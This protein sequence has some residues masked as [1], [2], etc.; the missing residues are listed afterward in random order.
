MR[1][2]CLSAD[3]SPFKPIQNGNPATRPARKSSVPRSPPRSA[4]QLIRAS[5]AM[6]LARGPLRHAIFESLA[7]VQLSL[8]G[9]L[10]PG[11]HARLDTITAD[12]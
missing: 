8:C 7:L 11:L 9:H 10:K 12:L 5:L 2:P 4:V 1:A 3:A 6:T